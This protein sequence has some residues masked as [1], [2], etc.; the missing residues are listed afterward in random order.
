VYLAWP[1]QR[2]KSNHCGLLWIADSD[3]SGGDLVGKAWK[4]PG[5]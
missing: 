5:S 3:R 4:S 1:M 2:E